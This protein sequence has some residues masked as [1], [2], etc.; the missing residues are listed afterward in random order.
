MPRLSRHPAVWGPKM[1]PVVPVLPDF[2]AELARGGLSIERLVT[3]TQVARAGSIAAAAERDPNR[4]ALFS[5]QM[6]Q[7]SSYFQAPLFR[8]E[9]RNRVLTEFGGE[10]ARTVET[11]L[12]AL[13]DHAREAE[14]RPSPIRLATGDS[15]TRWILTPRLREIQSA[16]PRHQLSLEHLPTGA[17]VDHLVAGQADLGFVHTGADL[18][19]LA[20]FPINALEYALFLPATLCP[21][22]AEESWTKALGGLPLITIDGRGHYVSSVEQVARDLGFAWKVTLRVDSLPLAAG[23]APACGAGVFLPTAAAAEMEAAG[24][25]PVPKDCLPRF[26]RRYLL[27]YDRRAASIRPAIPRL[28][29]ALRHIFLRDS[30][31]PTPGPRAPG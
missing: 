29:R 31:P 9:G 17:I 20:S 12:Q 1:T 11:F 2:L 30:A 23:M 6:T 27:V 5:R 26:S 10:V 16:C 15:V 24:Y 21:T 18:G 4:Q 14:D 25:R 3:F 22:A 13:A 28:V 19:R 8:T 7:L